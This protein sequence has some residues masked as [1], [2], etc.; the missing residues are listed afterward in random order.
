MT[1][2]E[3]S[4]MPLEVLKQFRVVFRA[5]QQHS[6]DIEKLLGIS[7]AQAWLLVE[8]R[9][10]GSLKAGELAA[11]MSIKPATLSNM[12][13]RLEELGYLQRQRNAQDMRVVEVALSDA[14]R[15]LVG[16]ANYAPR[17]WLPEALSRMSPQ[18][19]SSLSEGLAALLSVMNV[20]ARTGANSPLPFTE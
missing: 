6:S 9:D 10:N 18:Q 15:E 16:R 1:N 3:I 8:L 19:L 14:G 7:G 11:R 20:D 17:G 4:D 5:A 2:T 13:L 12:L